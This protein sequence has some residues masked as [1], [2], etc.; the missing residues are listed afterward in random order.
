MIFVGGV[1]QMGKVEAR[2]IYWSTL[3]SYTFGPLK[4]AVEC[5]LN[6]CSAFVTCYENLLALKE[7]T[8]QNRI[9]EF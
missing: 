9:F 7:I 3:I 5:N 8:K 1:G 2:L 6:S 4:R